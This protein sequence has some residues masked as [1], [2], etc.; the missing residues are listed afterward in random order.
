[1]TAYDVVEFLNT[2]KLQKLYLDYVAKE[3][4]TEELIEAIKTVAKGMTKTAKETGISRSGLYKALSPNVN[5]TI[6]A[7]VKIA[8][9]IGYNLNSSFLCFKY[10]LFLSDVSNLGNSLV[11]RWKFFQFY[12]IA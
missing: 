8:K 9:P 1:M 6:D 7:L 11:Y 10:I 2:E 12:F 5:P 3:G 4:T